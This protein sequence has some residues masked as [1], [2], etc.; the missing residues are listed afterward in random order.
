MDIKLVLHDYGGV[1]VSYEPDEFYEGIAELFGVAP[2]E[3]YAFTRETDGAGLMV[4]HHFELPGCGDEEIRKAFVSRFGK[5]VSQERFTAVFN[6]PVRIAN[7]AKTEFFFRKISIAGIRQG[8]ISDINP[9]QCAEIERIF[10]GLHLYVPQAMRFYSY[11]IGMR[12]GTHGGEI[13]MKILKECGVDPRE[14]V[15]IDDL[16]EN[17]RKFRE[18]GGIGIHFRGF[19]GLE[20]ELRKLG[21]V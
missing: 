18:T 16:Q 21:I 19:H 11:R 1:W 5:E 7:A 14:A 12:K 10:P 13:F 6:K 20:Y 8:I 2:H 9:I 17:I 4:W 3:V 15:L